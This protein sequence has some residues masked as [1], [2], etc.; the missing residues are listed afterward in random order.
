MFSILLNGYFVIVLVRVCCALCWIYRYSVPC[1]HSAAACYVLHYCS[2]LC[3]IFLLCFP[4]LNFGYISILLH[5]DIPSAIILL[6]YLSD[7]A[8]FS[9]NN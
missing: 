4:L 5:F 1:A 2:V 3:D 8:P 7:I 6:I 9:N